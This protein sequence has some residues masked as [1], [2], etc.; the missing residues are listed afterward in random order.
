MQLEHILLHFHGPA[1]LNGK[2]LVSLLSCWSCIERVRFHGG[3]FASGNTLLDCTDE[4]SA[5]NPRGIVHYSLPLRSL[6][7]SNLCL[8]FDGYHT[9][10]SLSLPRLEAFQACVGHHDGS[11]DALLDVLD[12]WAPQL[13]LLD[14]ITHVCEPNASLPEVWRGRLVEI[15]RKMDRLTYFGTAPYV[16]PVVTLLSCPLPHLNR[17]RLQY[18]R[19]EDMDHLT[20]GLSEPQGESSRQIFR[21]PCLKELQVDCFDVPFFLREACDERGIFFIQ[22]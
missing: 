13:R 19:E 5:L 14:L 8:P 16:I 7:I 17:L 9:L 11:D 15:V 4:S 12:M 2:E 10:I 1:F 20:S 21:L 3:A 22:D 6:R 18:T